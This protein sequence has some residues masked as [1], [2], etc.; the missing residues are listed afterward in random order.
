[1]RK[2]RWL[3]R[4]LVFALLLA[5]FLTYVIHTQ[6]NPL[7]EELARAKVSDAAS[8][9]INDAVHEMLLKNEIQYDD[10]ITLSSDASGRVTALNTNIQQINQLKTELLREIDGATAII[11]CNDLG[12]AIGNLSGLQV[13]NGR[14]PR[15]PVEVSTISSSD[16]VF[17]S[18][19]AS[20]G[21]NQT[22][23]RVMLDVSLELMILLPSAI[24]NETVSSE[25]C[26][27]ETVLLGTV[28][29]SYTHFQTNGNR[30]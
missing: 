20:A 10:L 6:I 21:I 12:V 25:L 19:F 14:G 30:S 22:I 28:P 15:I 13:L 29:E 9:L 2:H 24:L 16:A 8:N 5:G 1:M 17:R 3:R 27:A 23:H 4:F 18:E 11:N 26:V 7:V